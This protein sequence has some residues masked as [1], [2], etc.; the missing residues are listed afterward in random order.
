VFQ[1]GS[2]KLA[3]P[4]II[5]LLRSFRNAVFLSRYFFAIGLLLYL[6]FDDRYH[7]FTLHYQAGL[8]APAHRATGLSPSAAPL[9]G[10]FALSAYNSA[11]RL[12]CGLFPV[13]S[14]L[15][16]K[17]LLVSFPPFSDMLKSEGLSATPWLFEHRAFVSEDRAAYRTL[18][19]SS[20]VQKP[21]D[22]LSV[23]IVVLISQSDLLNN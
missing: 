11:C 20:S 12:P 10:G 15:L 3:S 6:A 22:P 16:R 18:L 19:R 5:S 8:L 2:N 9:S 4:L 17:S 7:H 21:R 13:H 23:D 1:D 14:P